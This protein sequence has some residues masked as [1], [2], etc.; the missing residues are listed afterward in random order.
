MSV[1]VAN[2]GLVATR[3][4]RACRELDVGVVGSYEASDAQALWVRA[5]DSAVPLPGKGASAYTDIQEHVKAALKHNAKYVHPG[6]GFLSESA[7]FAAAVAGAGLVF[8]GPS[9]RALALF[10]DKQKTCELAARIGIPVLSL[11]QVH[12]HGALSPE[13]RSALPLI[14]KSVSGGG[15]LGLRVVTSEADAQQAYA[16]CV[17]ESGGSFGQVAVVIAERF[18]A[19]ARHIEV[20]VVGDGAAFMAFGT[21]DCSVQRRFQKLV[22]IAPAPHVPATT[23]D[24]LTASA[25]ALVKAAAYVGVATVEF[26]VPRTRPHEFFLLEVNPRLQVEHTV[27]EQVYG[28]DLVHLQLKLARGLRLGE[29]WPH[30]APPRPNGVAV[31]L[32]VNGETMLATPSGPMVVASSGVVAA[33]DL[34]RGPGVRVESHAHAGYS[35]PPHFDSLLALVIVQGDDWAAAVRRVRAALAQTRVLGLD[36]NLALLRA[37]C[38][39]AAFVRGDVATRFVDEHLD[40]LTLAATASGVADAFPPP[41]PSSPLLSLSS[42]EGEASE[43]AGAVKAPMACV[44]VSLAVGEGALVR[45]GQELC[46]VSALKME[47]AVHA[48][49]GGSA[50]LRVA[51]LCCQPGDALARGQTVLRLV[52]E[53]AL[54]HCEPDAA[55]MG[56]A[57]ASDLEPLRKLVEARRL[58]LDDTS[59][60]KKTTRPP[61]RL[62]A[63]AIFSRVFDSLEPPQYFEMGALAVAYGMPGADVRLDTAGDA[64]LCARGSVNGMRAMVCAYDYTVLAGTQGLVGHRK[65]DRAFEQALAMR[66]PV[67]LFAEGGGGRASDFGLGSGLD[68]HAFTLF[69]KLRL[70]VPLVSVVSGYCFAGNATL[71]GGSDVVVATREASIGMGGP[72]MIEGGGLGVV[73]PENVGPA[74]MHWRGNGCVDVLVDTDEDAVTMGKKLLGLF[75]LATARLTGR[76]EAPANQERLRSTVPANRLRSFDVRGVI[77]VLFDAKSVVELKK[78][79]GPSIATCLATLGGVPVGVIA[80]DNRFS[81]G[82]IDADAAEKAARFVDMCSAFGLALVSLVDTPGFLVGVEAEKRGLVRRAGDMFAALAR[83]RVPMAAV[84]LRKSYGLGAMAMTGGSMKEPALCVAWPTSEFGGMQFEGA[85]RLGFR[86]VVANDEDMFKTLVAKAYENGSAMRIAQ[87]FEVDDGTSLPAQCVSSANVRRAMRL[88]YFKVIDPASTRNVLLGFV[89]GVAAVPPRES[90]L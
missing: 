49:V 10:G 87:V 5:L 42:T 22:E 57:A 53:G 26:L 45:P 35:P 43:E 2:R 51:T 86:E 40:A 36:T 66:L 61:G 85:V 47:H 48:P 75:Q 58:A 67:L 70:Q 24:A 16:R 77:D 54:A 15:G 50:M 39:H 11:G 13:Q 88:F 27:T 68:C 81:S 8:I 60:P 41:A 74:P 19:D 29:A 32:R 18:L 82:A 34:P 14:F 37:V 78:H 73:A 55:N 25:V 69:A 21:R 33:L 1:Y 65:M 38:A 63:R 64:F 12:G 72:A 59:R 62:T 4:T 46:V 84:V 3:V 17:S 56:N 6:I 30:A 83:S 90:R 89:Q 76:C 44:V 28:V 80:N 9:P 31:Q 71:V 79:W 23:L 7:E 20:Q 52:E